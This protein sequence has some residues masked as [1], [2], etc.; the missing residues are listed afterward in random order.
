MLRSAG[1]FGGTLLAGG[2][3]GLLGS[4]R[5]KAQ[6]SAAPAVV[7]SDARPHPAGGVAGP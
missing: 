6:S 4:H 2:A 3:Y 5:A 1:A 7:T